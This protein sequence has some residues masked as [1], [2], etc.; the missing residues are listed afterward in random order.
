[1]GFGW[2]ATPE[3]KAY[4]RDLAKKQVE[5]ASLPVMAERKQQWYAHNALHGTRPML[6]M[7]M[8]TFADS[9]MPGLWCTS[10]GAM[11]I[12]RQLVTHITSHELIDDDKVVPDVFVVPWLIH[13]KEFGIEVARTTAQD[14]QGRSLGYATDHP[15][16]NLEEDLT[17]LKPSEFYVDREGT[18]AQKAF[19]E[20][21]IGDIMPVEIENVS[22][23]WFLAPSSK[24]VHLMGMERMLLALMDTPDLMR[25]LYAFIRDQSMR[26]VAWMEQEN[27]LTLNNGNHYVGAGSY[28]FTDELPTA[29]HRAN[30]KVRPADLWVNVNS[31]E[32]VG[33]SPQMYREF[34]YPTYRD[35]AEAFGLSYY[36]CCEPVH[37]IWDDCIS[38][39]PHLRKVSVSPWCDEAFIGER[40]RDS[41]VIYSRKPS[42][43]L[44]GVGDFCPDAYREHIAATLQAARGCTLEIIHRDIYTL[45]GDRTRA[46]RAIAIARQAIDDL[47]Q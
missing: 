33:L 16:K 20:E 5:Y 9:V 8:A 19:V 23:R 28:G 46:G 10:P 11:L 34:I 18:L 41:R 40:L 45:V 44:I 17:K 32:T 15:I 1:M 21:V 38:Q 37:D 43:N 4:L 30:G 29:E 26:A 22:L 39:L 27:L 42:P 31:Q 36:G 6:V 3:E 47:W 12:E 13:I 7:E 14:A 35:M 25:E 24:V 2:T